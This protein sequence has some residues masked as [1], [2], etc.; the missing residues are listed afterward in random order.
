MNTFHK[1]ITRI[2]ILLLVSLQMAG[3]AQAAPRM[4]HVF[5]ALCD[6]EYQGIVPVPTKLGNGDDPDNNLYWGAMYGVKTFLNKSRH[7]TLLATIENPSPVP[8]QTRWKWFPQFKKPT[9]P[10]LERCIFRHVKD[11]VYLVADAYQGKEIKRAVVDFLNAASGTT[12]DTVTIQAGGESVAL[13]IHGGSQ[14]LVYVGHDGLM[15]FRLNA[16]PEKQDE[17]LREAIILAC[18]SKQYFSEA[19]VQAGVKPLLWTTG[20][21]APEAYTLESALEGWI[22]SETDEQ[23]HARAAKA[24]HT[25]QQCGLNAA[26]RLFA[27]GM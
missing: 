3:S 20:L 19:V 2:G 1:Q 18:L 13:P 12:R 14:L 27:T 6:N 22:A 26:K 11:D 17:E 7:W 16:Y 10:V 24:Y 15:D 8:P 21:M 25:Y 23:I 5:V 9:Q 4:L